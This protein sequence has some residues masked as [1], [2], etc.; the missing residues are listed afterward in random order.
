MYT[1]QR[2][3]MAVN[4]PRVSSGGSVRRYQMWNTWNIKETETRRHIVDWVAAVARGA[5]GSRLKHLVLSCHGL[6]GYLQL[7]EGFNSDHIA[8]F[9]VWRG[10]IEKIWLP[11]CLVARIP[12]AKMQTQLNHDYPGWGTSDGNVFCSK[13]AKQ[14][15]CYIVAATEKQCESVR[16]LPSDKM[17]SFE[18]LVL[19]YGPD[20]SVTWS[21]RNPSM[22]IKAGKCVSVPD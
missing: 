17:T 8:L 22:W 4:D 10:L 21:G 14:V 1:L 2:P 6:P 16:T 7:G 13:L 3:N 18:G 20:G 9:A 19:S 5:P 12:G 15:Q 11:N